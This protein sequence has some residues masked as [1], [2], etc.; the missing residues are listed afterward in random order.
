MEMK[1]DMVRLDTY[2]DNMGGFLD[3]N[4]LGT[5]GHAQGYKPQNMPSIG[6][7]YP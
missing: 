6:G 3:S 5:N 1:F 2:N 4:I 7:Q